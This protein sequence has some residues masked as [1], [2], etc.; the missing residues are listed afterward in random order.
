MTKRL[1]FPL[2]ALL[3]VPPLLA[4]VEVPG[5]NRVK[6]ALGISVKPAG[7]ECG[8]IRHRGRPG[9]GWRSEPGLGGVRDEARGVAIDDSIYLVGGLTALDLSVDPGTAT[10]V[11][12]FQRFDVKTR[13]YTSLPPLPA[14]LNHVV[15]A[16]YR[17]D[18]Y[19]AGGFND[20]LGRAEATDQAWRYRPSER[21][22]SEIEPMPTR[23]GG[24]GVAVVGDRMYVIGGQERMVR[25]NTMDVYDFETGK[26]SEGAPMPTARDHLGV[27]AY[28]GRIYVVGGRQP[29]DYSLGAFERYDVA[30]A[31]WSRL[32]DIPRP[33]SSF[34]LE[35]VSGR[36][37][38]AGGG[39]AIARPNWI[40]GQTWAYDPEGRKWSQL[41][42]M[43][44]P[45]HGYAAGVVGDRL[46]TFG[47]S[48]CGAFRA[49]E[50][51]ESLRVPEA[52]GL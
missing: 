12:T 15:V 45:R 43:P 23:R 47:G 44:E 28:R 35:L 37:V 30:R 19:V 20:Q 50:T 9:Q 13:R 29:R 26:W 34:E 14:R 18:V 48:S 3:A 7:Q 4:V 27:E 40:S 11:D 38:A 21:R 46:Y 24:A 16:A 32:P 25:K 6:D 51:S 39:D 5:E 42:R 2:L 10:S 1:L 33:A 8:E 17:G 41:A 49:T 31:K 36:L 52:R 22:W